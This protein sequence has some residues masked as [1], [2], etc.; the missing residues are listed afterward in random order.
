MNLRG[1]VGV[2]PL[3]DLCYFRSTVDSLS[4]LVQTRTLY[5]DV[6]STWALYGV[7]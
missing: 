2:R 6:L 5:R 1:G 4:K 7:V 3:P